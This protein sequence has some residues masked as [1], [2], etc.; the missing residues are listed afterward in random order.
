[1][2]DRDIV[3]AL[4]DHPENLGAVPVADVMTRDLL[5]LQENESIVDA[6]ALLRQR[7]VRRAPVVA[8]NGDLVGIVSTDDLLGIISEQL[9]SLARLVDRQ[10]RGTQR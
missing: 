8:P 5:V 4:P 7:G 2:T 1:V 6:M 10:T 3:R 9:G